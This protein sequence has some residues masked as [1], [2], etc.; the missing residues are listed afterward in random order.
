MLENVE[1]LPFDFN[2]HNRQQ[3]PRVSGSKL[4]LWPSVMYMSS[5]PR[6]SDA[7]RGRHSR[8]NICFI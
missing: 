2:V 4:L 8:W 5:L 3:E 1:P 7:A 6:V